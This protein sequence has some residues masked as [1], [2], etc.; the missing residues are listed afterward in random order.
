MTLMHAWVI[1]HHFLAVRDILMQWHGHGD[2]GRLFCSRHTG[3]SSLQQSQ[4]ALL[5]QT[6]VVVRRGSRKLVSLYRSNWFVASD[7]AQEGIQLPKFWSWSMQCCMLANLAGPWWLTSLKPWNCRAYACCN[8][9][10][11]RY[12]LVSTMTIHHCRMSLW[13]YPEEGFFGGI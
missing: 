4:A 11:S 5:F 13:D 7:I 12:R 3:R 2:A 1:L 6:R 8:L 9:F 10:S